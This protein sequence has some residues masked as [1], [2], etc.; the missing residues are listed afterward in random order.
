MSCTLYMYILLDY[1]TIYCHT[2][3]LR[4]LCRKGSVV[5]IVVTA[6]DTRF[7][8]NPTVLVDELNKVDMLAGYTIDKSYTKEKGNIIR[9]TSKKF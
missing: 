4:F 8:E 9:V 7:V 2:Y 6:L 3:C 1:F 5:A